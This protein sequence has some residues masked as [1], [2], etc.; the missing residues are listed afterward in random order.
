MALLLQLLFVLTAFVVFYSSLGCFYLS[1]RYDRI[2]EMKFPS[3]FPSLSTWR[4]WWAWQCLFRNWDDQMF[5]TQIRRWRKA[6]KLGDDDLTKAAKKCCLLMYITTASGIC[7]IL[8]GI[9]LSYVL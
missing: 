6:I 1:K 7:L 5:F 8:L 4:G 2:L 9:M 3:L